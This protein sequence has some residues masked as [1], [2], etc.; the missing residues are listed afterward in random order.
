MLPGPDAADG[1]FDVVFRRDAS[2]PF[3]I[4]DFHARPAKI[5]RDMANDP[6]LAWHKEQ[7]ASSLRKH[8]ESKLPEYAA[9]FACF[10]VSR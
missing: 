6:L 8:L 7:V 10:S 2:G 9:T 4:R 5:L 3:D 1:T